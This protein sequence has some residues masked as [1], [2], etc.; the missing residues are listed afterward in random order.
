MFEGVS[1]IGTPSPTLSIAAQRVVR[2]CAGPRAGGGASLCMVR[3]ARSSRERFRFSLLLR[4]RAARRSDG[5][6]YRADEK[7]ATREP[8][9]RRRSTPTRISSR[10]AT[11]LF[12]IGKSEQSRSLEASGGSEQYQRR[13]LAL[14]LRGKRTRASGL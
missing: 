1:S 8:F 12:G 7:R 13:R 2:R 6:I 4:I 11:K 9:K 10:L 14:F 3:A 5:Q